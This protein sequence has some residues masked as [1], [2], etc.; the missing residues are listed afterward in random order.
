VAAGLRIAVLATAESTLPPIRLR[1]DIKGCAQLV[2]AAAHAVTDADAIGAS[3]TSAA[4]F[5][6]TTVPNLSSPRPGLAAGAAA[7]RTGECE[8]AGRVGGA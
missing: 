6:T 7:V 3:M 2:A 4:R 8:S 1:G 5:T